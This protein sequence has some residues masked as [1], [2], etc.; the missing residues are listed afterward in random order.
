MADDDDIGRFLEEIDAHPQLG[1][2]GNS[3]LGLDTTIVTEQSPL[4]SPQRTFSS[5]QERFPLQTERFPSISPQTERFP[6]SSLPTRYSTLPHL[7]PLGRTYQP[8]LRPFEQKEMES[9]RQGDVDSPR[10]L[11]L[12]LDSVP[13]S[14]ADSAWV[15]RDRER[16]GP[17]TT[18]R[19]R[20]GSR[21]RFRTTERRM[22]TDNRYGVRGPSTS[23][24]RR[25][26]GVLAPLPE[27]GLV[28]GL[29]ERTRAMSLG[30]LAREGPGPLLSTERTA[31]PFGVRRTASPFTHERARTTSLTPSQERS[32]TPSHERERTISFAR[33][34]RTLLTS[35]DEVEAAVQLM[36]ASF[37]ASY[38]PASPRETTQRGLEAELA[39]RDSGLRVG[40]SPKEREATESSGSVSGARRIGSE[41]VVGRLELSGSSGFGFGARGS[42]RPGRDT[43]GWRD[44]GEWDQRMGGWR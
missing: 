19:E 31:S 36:K 7:S 13:P 2:A 23:G 11:P 24:E 5:T 33:R 17:R 16:F 37:Q 27:K 15:A 9:T 18:S 41:E 4:S 12:P 22:S 6:P 38:A 3:P 25:P 28:P 40:S 14:P 1:L 35:R 32:L 29:E 39:P 43:D 8:P 20:A 26:M 42:V 30:P 10:P 34:N 21:E 44:G